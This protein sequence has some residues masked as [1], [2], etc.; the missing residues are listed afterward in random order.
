MA[1]LYWTDWITGPIIVLIM[2]VPIAV[3]RSE[4]F[5]VI[6][7]ISAGRRQ[8]RRR[9]AHWIALSLLGFAQL[10]V[11]GA[12]LALVVGG[13][14]LMVFAMLA[15]VLVTFPLLVLEWRRLKGRF[16]PWSP[17]R[18]FFTCMAAD[19]LVL[20][21]LAVRYHWLREAAGAG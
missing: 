13:V 11:V 19:V 9:L 18:V 10:L 16:Q 2:F 4:L 5:E 7:H 21:Y 14:M 6:G 8:E 1:A 20:P 15:L 17:L 12:A 3:A